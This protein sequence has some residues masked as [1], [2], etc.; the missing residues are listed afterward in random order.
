MDL[1]VDKWLQ[2]QLASKNSPGSLTIEDGS[3][4]VNFL[5]QVASRVK[6]CCVA[7][8]RLPACSST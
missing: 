5:Q 7:Q 6:L 4:Q 8:L 1:Q 2:T 3:D